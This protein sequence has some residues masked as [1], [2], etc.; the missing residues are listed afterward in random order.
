VKGWW[1]VQV[2]ECLPRKHE[3]LNSNPSTSNKKGEIEEGR[4]EGK[5]EKE[6]GEGKP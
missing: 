2:V 6:I 5:K 1:S 3:A 4:K